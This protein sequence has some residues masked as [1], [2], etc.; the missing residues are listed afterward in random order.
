MFFTFQLVVVDSR[1]VSARKRFSLRWTIHSR[2][3][4]SKWSVRSPQF[5]CRPLFVPNYATLE[6]ELVTLCYVE[7]DPLIKNW[8]LL[9]LPWSSFASLSD[10]IMGTYKNEQSKNTGRARLRKG[11]SGGEKNEMRATALSLPSPRA[12]FA[13]LFTPFYWT[14]FHHYLGAWNRIPWSCSAHYKI[15]ERLLS[16]LYGNEQLLQLTR[17]R[18]NVSFSLTHKLPSLGFLKIASSSN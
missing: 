5:K 10:S 3:R 12:F 16:L 18:Y 15:Q 17:C 8:L 4:F 2:R 14:T 7:H 6:A 11:G 13:L 9:V 1:H